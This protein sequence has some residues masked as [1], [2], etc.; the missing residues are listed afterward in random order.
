[1]RKPLP[2]AAL[3]A[4]FSLVDV[5]HFLKDQTVLVQGTG[6]IAAGHRT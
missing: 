2:I 6:G 1:M 4:W 3:T 5:G